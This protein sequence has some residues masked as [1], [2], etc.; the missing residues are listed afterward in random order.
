[1]VFMGLERFHRSTLTHHSLCWGR[2]GECRK[3]FFLLPHAPPPWKADALRGGGRSPK[4]LYY[5]PLPLVRKANEVRSSRGEKPQ[6]CQLRAF[7]RSLCIYLS[8]SYID[9]SSEIIYSS[10]L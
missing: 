1:M 5:A 2:R 4:N 8:A 9:E 7:S 6:S 3:I 10:A